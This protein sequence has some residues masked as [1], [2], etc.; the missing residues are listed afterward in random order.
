MNPHR[1]PLAKE[2]MTLRL[3]MRLSSRT[4]KMVLPCIARAFR[5]THDRASCRRSACRDRAP[6]SPPAASSSR[7][8]YAASEPRLCDLWG[9]LP[10]IP[11]P[12]RRQPL[13]LVR[14]VIAGFI[15]ALLGATFAP[16]REAP[17]ILRAWLEALEAATFSPEPCVPRAPRGVVATRSHR[18]GPPRCPRSSRCRRRLR[19]RT[20]PRPRSP[21][22]L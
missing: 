11:D 17:G 1:T 15:C 3:N 22:P 4:V 19:P 2:A 20:A 16:T 6:S 5:S 13:G 8:G 7:P 18:S 12:P 10:P 14:P 21:C 9:M